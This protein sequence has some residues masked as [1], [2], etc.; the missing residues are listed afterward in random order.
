MK[1]KK[2]FTG[3]MASALMACGGVSAVSANAATT[4]AAT[5]TLNA[6]VATSAK[7]VNGLDSLIKLRKTMP[8]KGDI[9]G[10]KKVT[11]EDTTVLDVYL[12]GLIKITKNSTAYRVLDVNWDG[13]LDSSDLALMPKK[14]NNLK[15]DDLKYISVLNFRYLHTGDF[16]SDGV[17]NSK[18]LTIL[19]NH[20][21]PIYRILTT[22]D[23]LSVELPIGGKFPIGRTSIYDL[24]Q[25]GL[26]N[27]MDVSL[28]ESYI[29]YPIVYRLY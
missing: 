21:K 22:D 16:N 23:S 1:L 24:N 3:I 28:M 2:I 7:L 25:D 17:V 10:D 14:V 26:V 8:M 4:A 13:K 5:A 27:S 19:K 20:A 6:E 18:D 9:N 29:S 15:N 12:R 11:V